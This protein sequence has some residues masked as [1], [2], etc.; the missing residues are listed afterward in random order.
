M[1]N[2]HPVI[3]LIC[4]EVRLFFCGI[5]KVRSSEAL[6]TSKHFR[7]SN[8]ASAI[9]TSF[10]SICSKIYEGLEEVENSIWSVV[11]YSADKT[12]NFNTR[13]F[14]ACWPANY[15]KVRKNNARTGEGSLLCQ[16]RVFTFM[17]KLGP[18]FQTKP[19]IWSKWTS[20]M[21]KNFRNYSQLRR[22]EKVLMMWK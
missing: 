9:S 20:Y 19:K 8:N 22:K 18:A 3:G 17:P 2:Y 4:C 16:I 6:P 15:S 12:W 14:V 13:T 1:L 21:Q 10:C 5:F 11:Q 7:L